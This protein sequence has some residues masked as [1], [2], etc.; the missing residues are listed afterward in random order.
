MQFLIDNIVAT[1]I[2][3]SLFLTLVTVNHRAGQAA[4]ETASYYALKKQE[5][6]FI[7]FMQHDFQNVREVKTISG[8]QSWS[9]HDS[10]F[11]FI[12]EVRDSPSSPRRIAEVQYR[13]GFVE[14]RKGVKLFQVERYVNNGSGMMEP[15]GKSMATLT[16]WQIQALNKDKQPINNAANLDQAAA[17]RVRFE[18]A[19]PILQEELGQTLP[20]TRWKTTF[21]PRYLQDLTM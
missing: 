1:I 14:S 7:E 15:A 19:S 8:T 4:A 5:Y 10:T 6:N 3:A 12:G 21:W 2:T 13:Y 9:G 16:G 17:I 18:G 11:T 20:R